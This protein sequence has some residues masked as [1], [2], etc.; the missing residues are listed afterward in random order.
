MIAPGRALASRLIDVHYHAGSDVT[1]RRHSVVQAA[2]RYS[3]MSGWVVVK[4]HLDSTAAA[5]WE[6]R[7]EGLPVSG[8]VV[9]NSL[10]GGVDHRVVQRANFAHGD[11]SPARLVVYLPTLTPHA[12]VSALS[13][14][15]FHP[16][17]RR[18]DWSDARVTDDSGRLR[19]EVADVLR[20]ARDLDLIVATGHCRRE[21]A[22]SIVDAAA[23]I[24]LERILLT[25]ATHPL[26]GFSEPDI[27]LLSTAGHVWVEI[28]ALTVLMGHR[29][30]DH[31]ARLAASHPRVVLSSDLGQVTQPDVSEA[32]AMIDRWLF[33]L[34]VDREAVAVANPECLLAGN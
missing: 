30:L 3:A 26:S 25:H 14:E 11:D 1:K 9:L 33:D 20:C 28:T 24:G 18:E 21:E 29:G 6:A 13:G 10:A 16:R 2:R 34:A 15:P 4:S 17:F 7:Q 31:L 8:A 27:A 23:D 5:A 32:W 12:H 19:P 22:L